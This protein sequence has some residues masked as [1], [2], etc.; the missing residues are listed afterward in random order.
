[1][2]FKETSALGRMS[3][4]ILIKLFVLMSRQEIKIKIM[5]HFW[6]RSV[7]AKIENVSMKNLLKFIQRF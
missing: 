4:K 1:M 3:T 5:C 7:N 2:S 6:S